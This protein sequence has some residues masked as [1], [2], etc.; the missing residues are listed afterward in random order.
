MLFHPSRPVKCR[1]S[2]DSAR[3][4]GTVAGS[5]VR[6]RDCWGIGFC[7]ATWDARKL[8]RW[9][10]AMATIDLAMAYTVPHLV[11]DNRLGTAVS[12]A[13]QARQALGAM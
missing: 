1:F 13:G 6:Q 5:L 2:N 4:I 11:V 3:V 8:Q 7:S 9:D 10:E 12:L